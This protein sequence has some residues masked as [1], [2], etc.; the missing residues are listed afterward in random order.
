MLPPI[1]PSSADVAQVP[2][3][4]NV[5][6]PIDSVGLVMGFLASK[7]QTKIWCL[8]VNLPETSH[9]PWQP[10]EN[11]ARISNMIVSFHL[12]WFLT[13]MSMGGRVR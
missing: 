10:V 11:G 4:N 2:E 12:G 3:Q 6:V 8:L 7:S 5:K 13:S 1:K 9:N